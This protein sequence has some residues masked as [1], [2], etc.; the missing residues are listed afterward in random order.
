MHT[1]DMIYYWAR[2]IP[3]R[4]AIIRPEGVVTFSALAQSVETAADN[5]SRVILDRDQPVAVA[6]ENATAMLVA[7]LGLMRAGFNIV[8]ASKHVF[9]YLPQLRVNTLVY[10]RD[11]ATLDGAANILF[12]DRWLS[13]TSSV[14]PD[15]G[16]LG[17]RPTSDVH[18]IF[19]T[20]GT[21]GKPKPIVET[22][23]AWEQRILAAN[24]A[25]FSP[26]ERVLIVP[27]L[28]S[29][30]GH[31]RALEA[32]HFGK[33]VCFAPFGPSM[34]WLVNT[35]DI[36]LIIGSPQ[37]ALALADIQ[38]K[39]TRY[40]LPS[41]RAVKIGGSV[42]ARDGIERIK[43]HLCRNIVISYASTEAGTAAMAPHDAIAHVPGAVG[44][45][46]PGAEIEIVDHRDAILP[47][48]SE[49]FIRLRTPQFLKNASGNG[50]AAWFYPGDLG[51][52][53]P[54][55]VLCV[56]GRSGDVVN[57]G[58]TK[59]SSTEFE[60]FLT[61]FVG[62]KDAG[63]CTHLGEAGYEEVWAA[64]VLGPSIDL[65]A[66][67]HHIESNAEFGRNIDKLFVVESIPRNELAKI[68]PALLKEM[69]VSIGEEADSES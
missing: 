51:S 13:T 49:G 53:T 29:A 12:E 42:I 40:P 61:A 39:I 18:A 16:G 7:C 66:F 68:Q 64:V 41:L 54:D 43:Q 26:Y 56:M 22:R 10:Q 38:E 14:V 15:K 25:M 3:R 37:Q 20:S 19:F 65:A 50:G 44:Y 6:M 17:G 27:G 46:V 45:V 35:Y 8:P 5:L 4:P 31:N 57:R 28:S 33:T 60:S 52:L 58:G 67:R 48:G 9:E 23:L 34:L 21:T 62:V 47:I 59:L 69:L 2:T 63:I 32:L 1:I 30:Y 24:N 11:G 55:G 36:D